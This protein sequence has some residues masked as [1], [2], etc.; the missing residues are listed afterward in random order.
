[1]VALGI[2]EDVLARRGEDCLGVAPHTRSEHAAPHTTARVE[3]GPKRV[4]ALA[5][6]LM[7]QLQQPTATR[8]WWVRIGLGD[9]A[10]AARAQLPGETRGRPHAPARFAHAASNCSSDAR[11]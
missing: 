3:C 5:R 8:A 10:A 1:G 11:N 7:T 2:G 4:A 9:L 6:G